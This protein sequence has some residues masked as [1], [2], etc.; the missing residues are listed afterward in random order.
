MKCSAKAIQL[1]T[2]KIRSNVIQNQVSKESMS[3]WKSDFKSVLEIAKW[4]YVQKRYD[5]PY[6]LAVGNIKL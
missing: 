2:T 5:L 4:H 6:D 3:Q 1:A